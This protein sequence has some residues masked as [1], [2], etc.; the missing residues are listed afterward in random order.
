M[1]DSL[2]IWLAFVMQDIPRIDSIGCFSL[3]SGTQLLQSSR[4]LLGPFLF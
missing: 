2:D 4:S 1:V 3:T